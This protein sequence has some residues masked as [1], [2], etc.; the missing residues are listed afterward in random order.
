MDSVL[1]ASAAREVGPWVERL[2]RVGFLAKSILYITIGVLAA[3]A[4][5]GHGGGKTVTD[6][7]GAMVRL[8]SAPFGRLL[9][10]I[11]A[12]GLLGYA[13]WRLAQG[14]LDPERHGRDAKGIA[15]RIGA[16]GIGI[17]HLGLAYSAIM[18]ALGHAGGGG[19]SGDRSRHYSA[20]IL[21]FPGGVIA[22]WLVAGGFVGYGAYQLF[23]AYKTKLDKQLELGRMS[24]DA[25]RWVINVSRFGIAARGVVFGTI[26]VLFARAARDHNAS[27]AGGL[28]DSLH[29]LVDLGREPFAV[30]A[31]G[32]IAYGVYQALNARYRRIHMR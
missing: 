4:A 14:I 10:A 16:I 22:L 25:G 20:R 29:E 32:L 6:Q 21:E 24:R 8:I 18:L 1:P 26:G 31:F 27:E 28:G 13:V 3:Q 7:R 15:I 9:L 30:V 19:G 11:I 12:L 23:R 2:A 5:I 17:I